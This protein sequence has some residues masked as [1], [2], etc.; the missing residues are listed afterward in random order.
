MRQQLP[1]TNTS[2]GS[3]PVPSVPTAQQDTFNLIGSWLS[4][5]SRQLRPANS[6]A[7]FVAHPNTFPIR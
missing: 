3:A 5:I 6:L 2:I 1:I 4:A 7:G